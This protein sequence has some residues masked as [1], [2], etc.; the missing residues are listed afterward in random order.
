MSN[1]I[2]DLIGAYQDELDKLSRNGDPIWGTVWNELAGRREDFSTN[3]A[4]QTWKSLQTLFNYYYDERYRDKD[5]RMVFEYTLED[6]LKFKWAKTLEKNTSLPASN[7]QLADMDKILAE[8]EEIEDAM[9]NTRNRRTDTYARSTSGARNGNVNRR[10]NGRDYNYSTPKSSSGYKPR[11]SFSS[12]ETADPREGERRRWEENNTRQSSRR[13]QEEEDVQPYSRQ[14]S[15]REQRE[16]VKPDVKQEHPDFNLDDFVTHRNRWHPDVKKDEEGQWVITSLEAF[17]NFKLRP[18]KIFLEYVDPWTERMKLIVAEDGYVEQHILELKDMDIEDH[19]WVIQPKQ[20]RFAK[21]P[22]PE[23]FQPLVVKNINDVEIHKGSEVI[24]LAH[25]VIAEWVKAGTLPKGTTK[26]AEVADDQQRI[27]V[28]AEANARL[29]KLI[30]E[31]TNA[32]AAEKVKDVPAAGTKQSFFTLMEEEDNPHQ[33]DAMELLQHNESV[34][35]RTMKDAVNYVMVKQPEDG[36]DEGAVVP[37]ER[38][39]VL[40]RTENKPEYEKIKEVSTPLKFRSKDLV[41]AYRLLLEPGV[42]PRNMVLVIDRRATEVTNE[43]LLN[44]LGK[45]W[46]VESFLE[47]FQELSKML[48]D[49]VKNGSMTEEQFNMFYYHVQM[50]VCN[51][52]FPTIESL[53]QHFNFNE[54][55]IAS[56]SVKCVYEY[57]CGSF[58]YLPYNAADLGLNAKGANLMS[59]HKQNKVVTSLSGVDMNFSVILGTKDGLFYR[60]LKDSTNQGYLLFPTNE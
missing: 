56:Q 57:D 11:S 51:I 36:R 27:D 18:P 17:K 59:R 28:M 44:V 40:Y 54:E 7:K 34:P 21:T 32:K 19:K 22:P 49:E 53:K 26:I 31:T 39:D 30:Q 2:N 14:R 23:L 55:E 60:V 42:L 58:V 43:A 20:H 15:Q 16:E 13:R 48:K 46:S 10:G 25:E 24:R 8:L 33:G 45:P 6:A 5:E 38:T 29:I 47:D 37:Y 52:A 12:G 41:A 9:G 50:K 4:E 1:V 3:E 35:V